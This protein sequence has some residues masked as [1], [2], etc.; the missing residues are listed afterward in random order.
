MQP[1]SFF[2]KFLRF[3]GIVLMALTAGFTILG[4][5]GTACA[6]FDP[7]NPNWADTMG[8]LAQMQW[9]YIFY[10]LAGVALGI[11]GI[12]AIVLLVKGDPKAYR[13]T[14]ITLLTGI[15]I[16]AIHIATSRMLRGKSMPVDAVVY[17]TI[18]TLVIFLLFRLP[19]VWQSVDFSRGKGKD[20]L[21]AGGAAAIALGLLTLTIQYTMGATHTWGGVNYANAFNTVM[22]FSGA[23]C[24][25][26]GMSLFA[27][28]RWWW[29]A[30]QPKWKK[31]TLVN[32]LEVKRPSKKRARVLALSESGK[33]SDS[34]QSP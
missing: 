12:R 29:L 25:A 15:V 1:N 20:N 17:T 4:G 30:E 10:V 13:D 19:G 3:I 28:Q 9:L 33:V 16:G 8:P 26:T 32:F 27:Q 5:V 31:A 18:L 21:T 34:P 14:L 7:L 24:L 11:A 2:A 23:A 6:A 22:T